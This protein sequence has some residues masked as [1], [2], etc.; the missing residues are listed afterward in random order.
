MGKGGRLRPAAFLDRDGTVIQEREYLSD[1]AGVVLVPGAAGALRSLR[2]AGYLLVVVTNQ[3]GIGRGL[4]SEDDYRRVKARLDAILEGEGVPLD[5]TWYCPDDPR[6][7]DSPCRKPA[8]GMYREAAAALGIDLPASA[9]VG[10][11]LSDVLPARTLG[12]TGILVRTGYGAEQT[13]VPDWALIVDDLPSAA[14]LLVSGEGP[15]RL[16]PPLPH[17]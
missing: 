1:P 11:R 13:D 3:S 10:D 15:P 4:Y 16:D 8:T 7:G 9:Y 14:A 17:R 5:G 12:G 2:E 6:A